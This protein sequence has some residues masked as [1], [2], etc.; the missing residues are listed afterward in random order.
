MSVTERALH[1]LDGGAVSAEEHPW[2]DV[3]AAALRPEFTV[4]VYYPERG[5]PILFGHACAV[6]GCPARGNSHPGRASERW[7]CSSHLQAW[8]VAG[9]PPVEDWVAAGV[10]PV[11]AKMFIASKQPCA[12]VGCVRSRRDGWWCSF[13]YQRWL[14]AG[15]P[16]REGF[17][18]AAPPAPVG[19]REC[20]VPGC[21]FPAMRRMRRLCDAHKQSAK[22]SRRLT[23]LDV[24]GYLDLLAR[25]EA[26]LVPQYDFGALA[27]PLRSELRFAIQ[28]RLDDGR[29]TLNYRRVA[30][31][32]EFLESLGVSS[33]F[34]HDQA[35][36][37]R[38]LQRRWP[39]E[40]RSGSAE[41]GFIRYARVS[42]AHL[43]DRA[44]GVD[45]YAADV[46]LVEALGIPEFAY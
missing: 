26:L 32:V 38:Q 30:C 46:W 6:G 8:R 42:V 10:K 5:E 17:A 40:P 34:E 44:S 18:Q 39:S 36:W 3:L 12:A 35:W 4:D 11:A 37:E 7:L 25:D 22:N 29:F 2:A 20:E 1:V 23:G 24:D 45:P 13:H 9:H 43:W 19:D 16:D 14:K 27:E 15:R 31:A 28:H 21:R 33:L 41:K